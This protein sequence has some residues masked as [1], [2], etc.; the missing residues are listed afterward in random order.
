MVPRSLICQNE[1]RV[2]AFIVNG[3]TGK[4]VLRR[5]I[6]MSPKGMIGEMFR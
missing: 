3:N 5:E 6:M 2:K 1:W 4:L